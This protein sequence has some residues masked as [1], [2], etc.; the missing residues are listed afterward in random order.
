MTTGSGYYHDADYQL[1]SMQKIPTLKNIADEIIKKRNIHL[2]YEDVD[3]IAKHSFR[4]F[5][6]FLCAY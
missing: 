4:V 6:L 2:K 5:L 3:N 1:N